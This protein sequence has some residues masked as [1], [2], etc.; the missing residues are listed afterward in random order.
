MQFGKVLFRLCL[1]C[2]VIFTLQESFANYP[3][4]DLQTIGLWNMD[5]GDGTIL[6]D[7]NT[8]RGNDLQIYG[9]SP[10]VSPTGEA[11]LFG[12]YQSDYIN[13]RVGGSLT[14]PWKGADKNINSIKIETKFRVDHKKT[15]WLVDVGGW[16]GA[17]LY[18]D[19]TAVK[20]YY[21]LNDGTSNTLT[22]WGVPDPKVDPA[23]N[24]WLTATAIINPYTGVASV[25]ID[26]W[27]SDIATANL[28]SGQT[29]AIDNFQMEIG[30]QNT[31]GGNPNS[32]R[33]FVGAID[34]AKISI[35]AALTDDYLQNIRNGFESRRQQLFL[36]MYFDPRP[37]PPFAS[38]IESVY[39]KLVA[40]IARFELN[41]DLN[42]ANNLIIT[43]CEELLNNPDKPMYYYGEAGFHW[44]GALFVRI[45]ESYGPNGKKNQGQ[46]S[47]I[48]QEKI[49]E[50]M[51]QWARHK[52]AV[53]NA[54]IEQS[55]TWYIWASENHHIQR[56]ATNWGIAKILKNTSPYNEY[57]YDD[58][59]TAAEHYYAWNEYFKEYLRQRA[60]RGLFV[61]IDSAGYA[62]H[63]LKNIYNFYDFADDKVL[64]YRAN[65]VLDL[66]WADWALEQIGGVRGGSKARCYQGN[67][68]QIGFYN[69]GSSA[70]R[71]YLDMA[72]PTG[73]YPMIVATS[74]YRVPF[75]VMDI[76]LGKG[77]IRYENLS[78]RMGLAQLPKPQNLTDEW[79][80]VEPSEPEIARYTYVTPDF[81][82]G[83]S[84]L[85]KRDEFDWC[86]I[87]D[88]NRWHGVIFAG[89]PD[90]RIF[91]QCEG[92]GGSGSKV[93]TY[94]QQWS[95]QNKGTMIA[96]KLS[97][98]WLTG[99]MRVWFASVLDI[100]EQSG[101]VFAEAPSAY[102][103][104]KVVEGGYYRQDENWLICN[105]DYSPVIIEAASKSDFASFEAFKSAV[106]GNSLSYI[107][108]ILVYNGLLD[109]GTF[110]FYANSSQPPKLNGAAIDYKPDYTFRSPFMNQNWANGNVVISKDLRTLVLDFN[111]DC[112]AW[113]LNGDCRVDLD[114]FAILANDWN[115]VYDIYDIK[116]LASEWLLDECEFFIN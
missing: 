41:F 27:V 15:G 98:S 67:E 42:T 56:D 59:F 84:H 62:Q 81:V 5:W 73:M 93:N 116:M 77:N 10:T 43:A 13:S 46:V 108:N 1:I 79:Y 35:I 39:N 63:T 24:I 11:I 34:Y 96:Q 57:E 112:P 16:N 66:Y 52:S 12:N 31:Y 69:S 51:W 82:M 30:G 54:Q 106:I 107:N 36:N 22:V 74:E 53:S 19:S 32:A 40:A 70:G 113:D 101:W 104:V 68:C 99:N 65:G 44:H 111:K 64:S 103:A 33:G 94:N 4:D 95:I 97:T 100:T 20:F 55:K 92:L 88:Q 72:T 21:K 2:V 45:Y 7:V 25:E 26:G 50:C 114:D 71:F 105:N 28:T 91:P 29:L 90:A 75:A 48:A 17:I 38:T 78:R 83:T 14:T 61:E 6:A 47:T 76:A 9:C 60:K 37:A 18:T 23:E 110:T 109:S 89:H 86:N 85:P 3:N 49:L 87:S 80:A 58:G 115:N 8:D 102:A